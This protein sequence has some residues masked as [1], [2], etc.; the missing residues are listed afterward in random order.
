MLFQ[1]LNNLRVDEQ[2]RSV[3]K[4]FIQR[5]SPIPPQLPGAPPSG[6]G[7]GGIRHRHHPQFLVHFLDRLYNP[8]FQER[9][10]PV[11]A[12]LLHPQQFHQSFAAVAVYLHQADVFP[13]SSP[14]SPAC[15]GS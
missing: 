6:T 14:R 11:G 1:L 9:L 4:K 2:R 7:A 3:L 5:L 12:A 8:L 15:T 10:Q 13:V